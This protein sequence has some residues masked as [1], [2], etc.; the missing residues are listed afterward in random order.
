MYMMGLSL[1]LKTPP[2]V[3]PPPTNRVRDWAWREKRA[4]DCSRVESNPG[5]DFFLSH[6]F[7]GREGE[8]LDGLSGENQFLYL[9]GPGLCP[10][11]LAGLTRS[12]AVPTCL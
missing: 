5:S 10:R 3:W 2:D 1:G 4:E 6:E 11:L 9:A 12:H 8:G 7:G